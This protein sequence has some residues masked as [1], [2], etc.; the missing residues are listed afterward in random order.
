MADQEVA[1]TKLPTR[2]AR[3]VR[4][5]KSTATERAAAREVV[6]RHAPATEAARGHTDVQARN[7]PNPAPRDATLGSHIVNS[8]V[9]VAMREA[10]FTRTAA[11][12]NDS[13]Y[14]RPDGAVMV[15]RT[16]AYWTLTLPGEEPVEGKGSKLLARA[17]VPQPVAR[18]A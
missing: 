11:T 4:V 12:D 18:A 13:T 17:L 16:N 10:G 6:R 9:H 1:V 14:T 2:A 8:G 3:G 15:T 7:K 5:R